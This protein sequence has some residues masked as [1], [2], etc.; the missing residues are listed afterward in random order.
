M[1]IDSMKARAL[2]LL[3]WLVLSTLSMMSAPAWAQAMRE[4]L[5]PGDTVRI[6]V[7]RYPDL[8]TEA[9]LTEEGNVNVPLIGETKLS[10]MTPDQAAKQIADRM[11]KGDYILDPQI[12]VAVL[13]ARSRQ[14]SVLGFVTRPGRY[15]LDGTSARLSDVI[16]LAGGLQPTAS[17][18]VTVQ[19][20]GGG[21][22]ET[23]T[24]DLAGVMQRG[25]LSKNIEVRSGD[26]IFVPKAPVFYIYGEVERGGAYKLEPDLTV[27]QAIALA[28]GITPR[29]S[30]GRVQVRRRGEDGKWKERSVRLLDPVSADDVIFVR[31]SLF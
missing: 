24:V 16:A 8:T 12:G 27:T 28:G 17:D 18:F 31:E 11:K 29:G 3:A 2:T 21:K 9:R 1:E 25:D 26:S 5:G 10:G 15:V 4:V 20:G 14:V 13:Q 30:E 7:Y 19:R 23:L 22:A 6:T